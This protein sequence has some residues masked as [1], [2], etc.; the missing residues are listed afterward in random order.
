MASRP[1]PNLPVAAG[2]LAATIAAVVW[3]GTQPAMRV[4]VGTE[5]LEQTVPLAY[6]VAVFPAFGALTA[7]A[8]VRFRGQGGRDRTGLTAAALVAVSSCAAVVRLAGWLPLSGHALFLS[9]AATYAMTL[10]RVRTL[11]LPL[12]LSVAGLA[13]TAWYKL[14]VWGDAGWFSLSCAAGCVLGWALARVAR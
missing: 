5:A 1:R 13:V 10:P 2:A 14:A 3:F 6:Q 11:R 7:L 8:L 12:A 9:A 4:L